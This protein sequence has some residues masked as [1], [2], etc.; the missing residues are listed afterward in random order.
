[1]LLCIVL[2]YS[3]TYF[4]KDVNPNMALRVLLADEST[5]IRKAILMVLADLGPEVKSVPSGLDVLSVAKTFNPDIVLIDVLLTKKNGYEVSLELKS[6]PETLK[7]PIILMWS[8]FMQLD[9]TQFAASKAN[10]SIEKPFETST[11]RNKIERQLP[12][13]KTHPLR[14]VLTMPRLPNIVDDDEFIKQ[15]TTYQTLSPDEKENIRI[16]SRPTGD[17]NTFQFKT[18]GSMLSE[19]T[20]ELEELTPVMT[21]EV[22]STATQKIELESEQSE[23]TAE[24]GAQKPVRDLQTQ[25]TD[26]A[27]ETW[28]PNAPTKSNEEWAPI[29]TDQFVIQTENIGEEFEEVTSID[30]LQQPSLQSK[31]S[32]Q[33]QDYLKDSPVTSQRQSNAKQKNLSSFDEQLLRE[34]IRMTAERICWQIIPEVTE[35]IVREEIAKL[36]KGIENNS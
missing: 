22:E 32:E 9:F 1:M 3:D 28:A 15:K 11:L 24:V 7:I 2:K 12:Q 17:A 21:D 36:L 29:S 13:V 10:D 5:A 25:Y 34:E 4:T 18:E 6:D 31:I 35:R 19:S 33:I 27:T 8:N 16:N 23:M 30:S 26:S 20:E 14:S